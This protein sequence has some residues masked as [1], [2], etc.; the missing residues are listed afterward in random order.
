MT[1]RHRFLSLLLTVVL[2]TAVSSSARTCP[3]TRVQADG[4]PPEPLP[5]E[6]GGVTPPVC[7]IY[8]YVYYDGAPVAG[9][10][11]HLASPHGSLDTTT[12]SGPLSSFPYYTADLS[13]APLSVS[14][15]ETITITASYSGMVSRRTWT[16]RDNGQHVDLGLVA[17][18]QAPGLALAGDLP[19][20][21]VGGVIS[22]DTTW[23]LAGSPY[24]VVSNVLV[25]SGVRLTIEPGV[26]V[27]FNAGRSL[28]IDGELIARGTSGSLITFT[29]NVGT[30]PGDWGYILFTDS[31]VDAVYD[32]GG[33]YLSGSI[34]Q[35]AVIEYAG[36]TGVSENAA[37]R[38]SASSP[39]INHTTV[40]YSASA[41]I[42][43]FN[44]GAPRIVGNTIRHNTDYGIRAFGPVE[45]RGNTLSD[46]GGGLYLGGG[47]YTTYMV[48]AENTISDNDG[49]GIDSSQGSGTA[50]ISGNTITANEGYGIGFTHG[51]FSGWNAE[52]SGN[53]VA[54]NA[55]GGIRWNSGSVTITQNT[56][57]G[58]L[59]G[60]G[61]FANS[62]YVTIRENIIVGNS[63]SFEGGGIGVFDTPY[64]MLMAVTI[65]H[66]VI[67]EN[68]ATTQGGGVYGG[69]AMSYNSLIRN[70]AGNGAAA[71]FVRLYYGADEGDLSNNTILGN[72]PT[73]S[74]VLRAVSIS[75]HPPFNANNIYGNTG[76]ALYN[77][78]AQGTANVDAED[79]W[80]GT[81]SD[82]A[83][84]SLIYDWLD[85]SNLGLVDYTPYRT[86]HN[87]AAPISPPT[88]LTAT[89]AGTSIA[90][91]WSPNPESDLAGYKVYWDTD[92]GYPYTHS[93][94]V[95]NVTAYTITGV[96]PGVRYYVTV[97]AYD[98]AADGSHDWTDG[99]ESWFAGELEVQGVVSPQAA[100]TAAPLSGTPPL[101]V[102]FTDQST[103]AI[104]TWD[105][106]FGD[107]GASTQQHPTHVYTAPGS[108]TVTL[109]VSGPGGADSETKTNYITVGY[110][111]PIAAF[112]AAPLAGTAPLTVTFTDQSTG[113]ITTW[114]WSFGDGGV[115][116]ARHPAHIYET[117]GTYTV[118]LTVTGPGGSDTETRPGYITVSPSGFAPPTAVI[119]AITPDP[120]VQ[121][122]DTII[123]NGSGH[124]NDESGAYLVAYQWRSNL[125]G[126]LSSQEDFTAQASELSVGT[127]T[128]Y[129][130]VQDDEGDWSPE[131]SRS[132]VVQ[133]APADVRTLILVNRQKLTALYSSAEADQVLSKLNALAAHTSVK[134]LV[135]QVETDSAVASAYA[136]WDADPT[137]TTKTNA[138]TA[139]IRNLVLAQWNSHPNLEYLV[140]VGD[141]RAIPFRRVLDQTRYPE[142]NYTLVAPGST[143]GA[144]LRANMTLTDNY[145]SDKTP[146]VPGG[147]GWDGHDLYIPDLGT[148]RLIETPAEIIAQIDTFLAGDGVTA[149]GAIV[150]GYDFV[151]DGAQAMC[152]ALTGDGLTTD[153]TLIG[154][155]W[156]ASQFKSL[157]LNTRHDIVSINGHAS[158][159]LMGTP[160]GNVT[161]SDVA[162]A[163]ADHTRAIFYTLGCHSG[164]NVPPD[165]P[166]TP[167]DLAQA[168]VSRKASYVANTG[169]GWG[170][171]TTV[172]LSEQLMLDFSERLVYGQS[173]TVGQALTAAKHEYY[174]NKSGFDYYDEKILIES[175]LYGLPMVRFTTPTAKV[176]RA[177]PAVTTVKGPLTA[178]GNGLTVN[179]LSYWFPALTA[180]ST[181][182]GRYYA[183]GD[184][185]HTGH[186]EPIQPQYVADLSFPQTQAHGVVFKGG[187]YTDVA[188]FNPVV[189]QAVTETI[190]LAE[191]AFSAPGWYPALLPQ[192][193]R[194]ERGDRLVTLLGQ[195]HPGSQTE[196]LY[197]RLSFDVYY[198]TSA[199]DW[200]APSITG[201]SSSLGAGAATITVQASD[202]SGI[203]AV[204]IAYTDGT[205]EWSSVSLAQSG[206]AWTGSFP[207]NANTGFFVQAVDG[208]GNVAVDDHQGSYY[209]PGDHLEYRLFLPLILRQFP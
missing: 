10:S 22:T 177:G 98:T 20:T 165:N 173:A 186:G 135:V 195:Y 53:T 115:S 4:S 32:G 162:G 11:V 145:Y 187:V 131:V 190:P 110:A 196:R 62:G 109:T 205:G 129:F 3:A 76:Y 91:S 30:S 152:G 119:D 182:D 137:N 113:P 71:N 171:L 166:Y 140:L 86:S 199:N 114:D 93:M 153:C 51:P 188:S 67:A 104:T 9:A 47:V 95:G 117:A 17:G 83:I 192:L 147:A 43:V 141:D 138:V 42:W 154:T 150:T 180:E 134:G 27:R 206:G 175:T 184:M 124:D 157:V 161:S 37:L 203:H 14:A 94:D 176:E 78:N 66:N 103:G 85:D 5:F 155:S 74:G 8:G 68:T 142:S 111:A 26:Q 191:P 198:H 34:I 84:Q 48:I 16:A 40:H 159:Y 185:V 179:S 2:L 73:G 65:I 121:G 167:L 136:A 13:S 123:F 77:A 92:S 33:N 120:A 126:V 1:T 151:K 59:G 125:D 44:D 7:C 49:P 102:T 52:I 50:A 21:D 107:G 208:A 96:T 128:I 146:T 87:T 38:I 64:E 89:L 148:G 209:Q 108:Y 118:T 158:H 79:N 133:A 81:A 55:S 19:S 80:W 29:S 178:L 69:G 132:L 193:N 82:P 181:P 170:S 97:T 130:K 172:G 54:N 183:L 28:Q 105:W 88:G 35:Y 70:R 100:F 144:A 99:N 57:A 122:Q 58:N 112:T 75:G 143:T 46:N 207:A 90:V 39:Y 197:D 116:G 127:H 200:T 63:A 41:G 25:Q 174:L 106:S 149:G 36:G 202:A 164:L 189:D 201:M 169:Y 60:G 156:T 15:G 139:A 160:L 101:T 12:A 204:V 23:T 45:I 168:L 56:I 31:S 61:V 24:I 72:V 18:Y 163:A 6:C 194:L